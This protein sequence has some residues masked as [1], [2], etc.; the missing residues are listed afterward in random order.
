VLRGAE[1]LPSIRDKTIVRTLY[2]S[3]VRRAQLIGA[4]DGTG[5]FTIPRKPLRRPVKGCRGS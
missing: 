5:T 3:G 1:R 2:Y 4:D